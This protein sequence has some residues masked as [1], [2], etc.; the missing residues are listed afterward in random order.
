[1]IDVETKSIASQLAAFLVASQWEDL[2]SMVR[3]EAARAFFNWTGCALGGARHAAVDSSLAAFAEL[4]APRRATVL[5]RGKQLDAQYSALVNALAS[6]IQAFDDTHE[7]SV[8]HPTGPVAAALLALSETVPVSGRDL[9]HALVLG[10]DVECRLSNALEKPPADCLVGWYLTGITGAVGAAA[11]VSKVLR[12]DERQTTW[13]LGLG[14]MQGAGFRQA[15][16]NM[17]LGFVP[18]HAAR[19]GFV[20]ALMA[21]QNFTCSED[22]FEGLNGFFSVYARTPNLD[23]VTSGLGETYEIMANLY[24]PYPAGI[25]VHPVID[26]CLQVRRDS[27]LR[28][29]DI[30]SVNLSVHPLGFKLT[31]KREPRNSFDAQ[32]SI[33]HWAAVTL[34]EGAAGN[35]QITDECVT[36]RPVVELRNRVTAT[37]DEDMARDEARVVV[38]LRNGA[39]FERHVLHCAGSRARPLSDAELHAKFFSLAEGILPGALAREL[40]ALCMHLEQLEDASLIAAGAVPPG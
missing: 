13:A 11:A 37:I 38:R 25:F 1:M 33:Y 39:T 9:L 34:L 12:L 15:H 2:P 17:C 22:V 23:A 29:E 7:T 36:S 14:A 21:A 4:S 10:I 19:E 32:V 16:G 40:A 8:T 31:G 26:A 35:A 5:G 27:D 18:G 6:S 3:S 28:P 30:E 20:A 24:K